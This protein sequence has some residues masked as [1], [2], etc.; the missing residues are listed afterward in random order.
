MRTGHRATQATIVDAGDD[1][2]G[3]DDGD[4]MIDDDNTVDSERREEDVN[5]R[6]N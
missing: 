2:D 4:E 1:V 6:R 5:W 3:V